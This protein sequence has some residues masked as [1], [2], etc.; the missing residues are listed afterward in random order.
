VGRRVISRFGTATETN[1]FN[2]TLGPSAFVSPCVRNKAGLALVEERPLDS[3][4]QPKTLYANL[5]SRGFPKLAQA[6]RGSYPP[7]DV[8]DD[9]YLSVTRLREPQP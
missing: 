3:T 5:V 1:G 7:I 2:C 4:G 9:G 8:L 6:A